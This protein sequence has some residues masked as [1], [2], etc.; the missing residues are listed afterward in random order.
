MSLLC[1][2]FS[3][4]L[5]ILGCTNDAASHF[6]SYCVSVFLVVSGFANGYFSC[7]LV[8]TAHLLFPR[9]LS[10]LFRPFFVFVLLVLCDTMAPHGAKVPFLPRRNGAKACAVSL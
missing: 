1:L 9:A 8:L 3:G 7:C 2:G 5:V 10:F 6:R 4:F